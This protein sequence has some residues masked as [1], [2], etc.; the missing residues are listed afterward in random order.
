ME[1]PVD[2]TKHDAQKTSHGW[3]SQ[4]LAFYQKLFK[5][6]AAT[7]RHG[8]DKDDAPK[9][10]RAATGVSNLRS[11]GEIER[12]NTNE[13]SEISQAHTVVD[14]P[15]AAT[16]ASEPPKQEVT[17]SAI[18]TEPPKQDQGVIPVPEQPS[19]SKSASSVEPN[20]DQSKN[21]L[22][23]KNLPFKFKLNDLEKLL[24]DHQ[25]KPK[26][27]RLLRDDSGKF[28]GMAFIRCASKD[29]AQR[30]I[31]SMHGLDIGGRNIQV[32]FKTKK[33]KKKNK[34]GQSTDSLNS[35]SDEL[36]NGNRLR[37][38]SEGIS[39][40]LRH[41]SEGIA[42]RLRHSSEGIADRVSTVTVASVPAPPQLQKV[43]QAPPQIQP[44]KANFSK[45]SVS[46]E[47]SFEDNKHSKQQQ[48]QQQ[49]QQQL[50]FRRKSLAV[51]PTSYLH[52]RVHIAPANGIR[53]V[54]QP[55][56]PDGKTNGFSDAYQSWR[57]KNVK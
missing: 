45:L 30:L 17:P 27:V 24:N 12:E 37:L 32:E 2:M 52:S 8:K 15:P 20:N 51:E 31:T 18:T 28:T 54:R 39:D 55:V 33:Q 53:P 25:A 35:S 19:L 50:P 7:S 34:L 22:V 40:R 38:S 1:D 49:Q 10:T 41:S 43:V 29:D 48:Q 26:N 5:S 21:T 4:V 23:I 57:S 44:Q 46:A 14:L 42:E 9:K 16:P 56:G 6:D 11:A 13:A 36:P 3:K 47:H